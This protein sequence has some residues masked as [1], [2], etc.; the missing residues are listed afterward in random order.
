MIQNYYSTYYKTT[1]IIMIYT[2]ANRWYGIWTVNN[3]NSNN[4]QNGMSC[5]LRSQVEA[6]QK[7]H[8]GFESGDVNK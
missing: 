5:D 4:S 8:R 1:T 6:L 2:A 3:C 7:N